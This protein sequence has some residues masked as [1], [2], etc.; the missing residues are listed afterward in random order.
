MCKLTAAV[1]SPEEAA[2]IALLV[3][4]EKKCDFSDV[5]ELECLKIEGAKPL[6]SAKT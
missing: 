3:E 6:E 4:N 1:S 2:E 5:D